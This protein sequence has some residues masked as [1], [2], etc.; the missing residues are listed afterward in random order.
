MTISGRDK[1]WQIEA[2]AKGTIIGRS[3]QCDVV[4]ETKD[5]SRKHAR[6]F[7][8]PFGRW[9]VEDLGS[10]NG[11]YVNGQRIEAQAIL[12]G[13]QINIGLYSVAL[14]QSLDQQI[15]PEA[16][17]PTSRALI[18]NGLTPEVISSIE[19][20]DRILSRPYLKQLNEIIDR[21]SKLTSSSVLYSEVCRCLA[22]APRTVVAVLRLSR[23]TEPLPASVD[24]LA[25]HFGDNPDDSTDR[26]AANLCLSRRV[27]EAV[28]STGNAVLATS[29]HSEAEITLTIIDEH[30]PRA[31]ICAPVS[32]VTDTVDLL[33]LDLPI[34][35]TTPDTFEFV[36]AVSRQIILTR[37]ALILMQVKA[38]RS[39]LDDQLSLAQKIQAELTPTILQDVPGVDLAL[40]Y[41]PAMWVGGDYCDVWF[42]KD[43]HLAF[44]IGDVSGKG[45]PAAMVMSNL[46]AALRTTMSFCSE[47][48]K[49]M[50]HVNLHLIQNLPEGMFVTLFLG[51]L[52]PSTGTLEYVN[53]GHLQP[54]IIQPQSTVV[55]LGQPDNLVLGISD[56]SFR[57]NVETIQ[58]AAGLFVFTDGIT[59]A[60][61]SDDEEFGVKRVMN[62]LK[63]TGERSAKRIVDL[64]T[65]AVDDFRQ[66]RPQQDDITIFT[67]FN[68]GLSDIP[69]AF[70]RD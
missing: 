57:T 27:L 52:D 25:W 33:Y 66:S 65:K 32:D 13:D 22:R 49:V 48:S 50:K 44:A 15:T 2:N 7:Q 67:L 3:A 55:P 4:I 43:G 30:T 6:I 8:D 24:I 51:L 41:K 68:R 12:P 70:R 31:V 18:E 1:T 34:N 38:E 58:E 56:V 59:E 45:L 5:I 53:A 36:K 39:I 23:K 20:T 69:T 60:R 10:Q 16:Y 62:L 28:R 37:K 29:I 11:V 9:I 42:L 47:L 17:A 63:T 61:S 19:T 54:L 21:L 26:Y 14:A 64:V 35:T 40:Y 46:Q